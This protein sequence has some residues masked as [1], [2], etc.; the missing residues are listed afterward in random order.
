MFNFIT[1]DWY[2]C[3]RFLFSLESTTVEHLLVRELTAN[4]LPGTPLWVTPESKDMP[5]STSTSTIGIGRG[6]GGRNKGGGV[7]SGTNSKKKETVVVTNRHTLIKLLG[8]SQDDRL[9]V[10]ALPSIQSAIRPSPGSFRVY[11]QRL[12][13]PSR[14]AEVFIILQKIVLVYVQNCYDRNRLQCPFLDRIPG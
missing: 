13:N 2:N 8:F 10:Q 12:L 4:L 6:A 7:G 9:V 1:R 3:S 5:T 14:S 11:V